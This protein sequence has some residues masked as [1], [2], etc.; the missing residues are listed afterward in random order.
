MHN[1]GK[2]FSKKLRVLETHAEQIAALSTTKERAWNLADALH[3][4]SP[5]STEKS[6]NEIAERPHFLDQPRDSAYG[7]PSG[8]SSL[9]TRRR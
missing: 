4:L 6:L 9:W 5:A 1:A 7:N 2:D 8:A 3:D